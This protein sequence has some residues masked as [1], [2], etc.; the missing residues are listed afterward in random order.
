MDHR[1]ESIYMSSH[2]V[3]QYAQLT[4]FKCRVEGMIFESWHCFRSEHK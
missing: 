3:A 1:T 4:D 2:S